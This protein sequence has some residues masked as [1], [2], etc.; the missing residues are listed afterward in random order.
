MLACLSGGDRRRRVQ[1]VRRTVVEKLDAVVLDELLPVGGGALVAIATRRLR[2]GR[3]VAAADGH[4]LRHQ[5]RRPRHV[6]NLS[7]GVRVGLAHEGVAQH[8]DSDLLDLLSA[9]AGAHRDEA[10]LLLFA[11]RIYPF[12]NAAS[13]ATF[14]GA[15]SVRRTSASASGAPQS[16]SMPESSHS[17][18]SGPSYPIRLRARKS[19]SKSTSP[20]PGETNVQPRSGSPK[21][22]CEPRI[23]RRPS[24]S[25]FESL[26]WS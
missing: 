15:K 6:L 7:V 5:R 4:E 16:R 12:L 21:S 13:K 26:T 8:A 1:V 20:W 24:R 3:L 25:F 2:H 11:H 14:E 22:M 19:D 17:I 18:D 9:C 23:D 10:A